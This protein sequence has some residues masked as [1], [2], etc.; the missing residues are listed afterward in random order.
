MV[1]SSRSGS[2]AVLNALPIRLLSATVRLRSLSPLPPKRPTVIET[3]V[4]HLRRVRI[5]GNPSTFGTSEFRDYIGRHIDLVNTL[6]QLQNCPLDF[7]YSLE[8]ACHRTIAG[9]PQFGL[10]PHR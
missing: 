8:T 2:L 5:A 4:R 7:Q 3:S 9:D 1:T 6:S 10:A